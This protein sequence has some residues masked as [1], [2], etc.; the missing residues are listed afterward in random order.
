MTHLPYSTDFPKPGDTLTAAQAN[1]LPVG[2]AIKVGD[3]IWTMADDSA[4]R[5]ADGCGPMMLRDEVTLI[6]VGPAAEQMDEPSDFQ[7][8]DDLHDELLDEAVHEGLVGNPVYVSAPAAFA[9]GDVVTREQL[10][11]LPIGAVVLPEQCKDD[12][13]HIY[14]KVSGGWNNWSGELRYDR[15]RYFQSATFRIISLPSPANPHA[16]GTLDWARWA[17][18]NEGV[19][20]RSEGGGAWIWKF[21]GAAWLA[22]SPEQDAWVFRGDGTRHDLTINTIRTGWS[23]V[24]D[25]SLPAE[26]PVETSDDRFAA[27]TAQMV[28]LKAELETAK[29]RFFDEDSAH[30]KT[31]VQRDRY[32]DNWEKARGRAGQAEAERDHERRQYEEIAAR[33]N[34]LVYERDRLCTDLEVLNATSDSNR[35]MAQRLRTENADLLATAEV[36]KAERDAL[37]AKVQQV[38]D[39]ANAQQC[40]ILDEKE[41]VVRNWMAL[42]DEQVERVEKAEAELRDAKT[43]LEV[44]DVVRKKVLAIYIQQ[45]TSSGEWKLANSILGDAGKELAASATLTK[46]AAAKVVVPSVV[47]DWAKGIDFV[48]VPVHVFASV[49]CFI[50]SLADHLPAPKQLVQ[51][52]V[53]PSAEP[54]VA[55]LAA[56]I[57]TLNERLV[58][59]EGKG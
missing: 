24:P 26:T 50:L 6:R 15:S 11:A 12:P 47:S 28:A 58:A 41:K 37:E 48:N 17:A 39:E 19:C 29:R 35:D 23:I 33:F 27:L 34:T 56:S 54:T 32:H 52:A 44:A 40:R 31:I 7:L 4:W 30:G 10:D 2:S 13:D 45:P 18:E 20:V 14:T 1:A 53:A 5:Q 25:P 59:L 9:V 42:H 36:L 57:E 51:S 16:S 49:K 3:Q 21:Q 43:M 38:A 8:A 22:W 55:Q 46:P